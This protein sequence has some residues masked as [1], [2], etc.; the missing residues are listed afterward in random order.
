MP[1]GKNK[2]QMSQ[3]TKKEVSASEKPGRI[4]RK[5]VAET[6]AMK[7][8]L[9][10]K[11]KQKEITGQDPSVEDVTR[12]IVLRNNDDAQRAHM[13]NNASPDVNHSD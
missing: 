5:R 7:S 11:H 6:E 4:S 9:P 8:P 2:S 3:G 10:T 1:K 12:K 13:N